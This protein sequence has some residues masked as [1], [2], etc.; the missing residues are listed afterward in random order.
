MFLTLF[1]KFSSFIVKQPSF[2]HLTLQKN[3][4]ATDSNAIAT[5][6][7]PQLLASHF[8]KHQREFKGSYTS[9]EDY[10]KGAQQVIQYGKQINYQYKGKE[11]IGY[12]KPFNKIPN[13]ALY[14]FVGTSK[15]GHIATYHVRS[16]KKLYLLCENFAKNKILFHQSFLKQP[17]K[18]D[19]PITENNISPHRP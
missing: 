12:F 5:F 2:F 18:E 9:A 15:K 10:L 17:L 11:H 14:E 8:L 4:F 6:A 1:K 7:N 19:K 13:K 16:E 3:F